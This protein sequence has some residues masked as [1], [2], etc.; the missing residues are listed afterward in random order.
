M[1]DKQER[2]TDDNTQNIES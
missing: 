1:I 2:K